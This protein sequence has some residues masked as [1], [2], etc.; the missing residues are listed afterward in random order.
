MSTYQNG[1]SEMVRLAWEIK[2]K[3]KPLAQ[4]HLVE[5]GSRLTFSETEPN[6]ADLE[7]LCSSSGM[8]KV[9]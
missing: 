6:G 1:S 3:G 9:A 5:P 4:E 2:V 8:T 7:S